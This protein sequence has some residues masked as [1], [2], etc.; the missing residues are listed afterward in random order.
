MRF[1]FLGTSGYHP[2]AVRHT[3]GLAVP[4][5]GVLFDAGSGTFRVPEVFDANPG[6]EKPLD[7]YLTHAHLDHIIGLTFFIV[8]MEQQRFGRV[9]VFA[10]QEVHDAVDEHLFS[11]LIF[12]VRIGYERWLRNLAVGLGNA[13]HSAGVVKALRT[14]LSSASELVREHVLW[15]L[16]QQGQKADQP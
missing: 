7:I 11:D 4:E 9:R 5:I 13:P 10:R 15:A 14:R 1:T 16:D 2:S 3:T 8:W 6:D 12:P